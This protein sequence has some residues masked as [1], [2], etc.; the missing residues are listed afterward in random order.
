M[1]VVEFI[2]SRGIATDYWTVP[3]TGRLHILKLVHWS[4]E[5]FLCQRDYSV[6]GKLEKS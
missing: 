4:E 2:F 1:E 3:H 5:E 6:T